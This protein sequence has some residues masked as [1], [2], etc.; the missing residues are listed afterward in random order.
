MRAKSAKKKTPLS[1]TWFL[2]F[3]AAFCR[4]VS[5][6]ASL[7]LVD[8]RFQFV[9]FVAVEAGFF[10]PSHSFFIPLPPPPKPFSTG[11]LGE[12]EVLRRGIFFLGIWLFFFLIAL[13]GM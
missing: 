1:L 3:F 6:R 11:V 4:R 2:D 10:G 8:W 7:I 9:C 13:H 5:D 12:K